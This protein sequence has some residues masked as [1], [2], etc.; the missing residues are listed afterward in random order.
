MAYRSGFLRGWAAAEQRD[1]PDAR[2]GGL[3]FAIARRRRLS[4]A[5][6][7]YANQGNETMTDMQ[8]IW[9][10]LIETWRSQNLPIQKAC[11]E[12][13]LLSF[14]NKYGRAL[15]SDLREY[16]RQVNGMSPY[17]PGDQDTEGFS[18]WP[19]DKI[20]TLTEENRAQAMTFASRAEHNNLFLFCDYLTWCWAYAIQITVDANVAKSV[21]LVCCNDPIKIAE[22]YS[23]F[24]RLFLGKSDG[25]YPPADHKHI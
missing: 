8:S 13:E 24:V 16:F 3:L 21:Y 10:Q 22:S 2:S 25:L 7:S 18:F 17:W 5:L 6:D 19:I 14:E 1:Q 4:R 23:D 11:T 20:C 9:K 15:P 12:D